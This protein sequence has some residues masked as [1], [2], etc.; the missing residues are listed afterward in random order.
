MRDLANEA[1]QRLSAHPGDDSLATELLRLACQTVGELTTTDWA[2]GG[3]DP[4]GG[5]IQS[6]RENIAA[7]LP[8]IGEA[9]VPTARYQLARDLWVS[10]NHWVGWAGGG[11][12]MTGEPTAGLS[13]DAAL[14]H[15]RTSTVVRIAVPLAEREWARSE[16]REAEERE[17]E[18]HMQKAAEAKLDYERALDAQN[19]L[20]KAFQDLSTEEGAAASRLRNLA[21]NVLTILALVALALIFL[22]PQAGLDTWSAVAAPFA[23]SIPTLALAGY[24]AKESSQHRKISR[25]AGVMAVQLATIQNY[26]KPLDPDQQRELMKSF[27][28]RVLGELPPDAGGSSDDANLTTALDII[29]RVA[30]N[31]GV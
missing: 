19:A 9:T 1:L 18:R 28:D 29:Q 12:T 16:S 11:F 2:W 26:V 25:W 8:E 21:F 24:V 20:K 6:G 22:A 3:G 15:N 14:L 23:I 31:R 30:T 27:G 7:A 4:S 5:L 10:L 13:R 17:L